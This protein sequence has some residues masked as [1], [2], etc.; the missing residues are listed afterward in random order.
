M[1]THGTGGTEPAWFGLRPVVLILV[2]LLSLLAL[3]TYL[4]QRGVGTSGPKRPDVMV[5]LGVAALIG[6]VALV[7]MTAGIV[8]RTV[9]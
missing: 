4:Q 3:G 6:F 5:G 7:L 8:I 2:V 1:S 9:S